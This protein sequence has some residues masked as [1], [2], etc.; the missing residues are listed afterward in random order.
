MD[1]NQFKTEMMQKY[2]G[3][4]L[5]LAL[6]NRV[7]VVKFVMDSR[8]NI[9]GRC[10]FGLVYRHR[11][12][13]DSIKEGETWVCEL[14]ENYAASGQYFA[15]GLEKVDPAFLMD[16][17]ADQIGL[18]AQSIWDNHR[19]AVENVMYEKYGNVIEEKVDA[20][21]SEKTQ[22]FE[23]K[24][25]GLEDEIEVLREEN[26]SL[27]KTVELSDEIIQ[28]LKEEKK[29]LESRLKESE[30]RAAA[31]KDLMVLP[32]V[33]EPCASNPG[34][35]V[36]ISDDTLYSKQLVDGKYT[37][38]VSADR[39]MMT[40]RPDDSGGVECKDGM[41]RLGC[42]DCIMD[43]ERNVFRFNAESGLVQ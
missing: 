7:A 12:F 32:E 18:V 41:I 31:A 38:H 17:R 3:K 24:K 25:K 37:V 19:E 14:M 28:S 30:E 1:F 34:S 39:C 27:N 6:F 20:M 26:E 10:R 36:R 42:L 2:D 4:D 29:D 35:I 23:T 43:R 5:D 9:S 16:L 13:E 40:I 22:A 11:D 33:T 15:K 21:V 8:G